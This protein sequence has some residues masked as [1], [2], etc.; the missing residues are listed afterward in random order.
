M[1]HDA[2]LKVGDFVTLASVS[3]SVCF[4]DH[5]SDCEKSYNQYIRVRKQQYSLMKD[6]VSPLSLTCWLH[7]IGKY[8]QLFPKLYLEHLNLPP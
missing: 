2:T 8:V 6:K 4:C 5:N 1:L 7:N 3:D